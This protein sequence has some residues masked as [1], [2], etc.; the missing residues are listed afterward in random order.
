MEYFAE[1]KQWEWGTCLPYA[2]SFSLGGVRR[3][4]VLLAWK[5]SAA[6]A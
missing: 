2:S 6:P 4:R 1:A 3:A 5:P